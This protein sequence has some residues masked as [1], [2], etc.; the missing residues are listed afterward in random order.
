MLQ[1]FFTESLGRKPKR[2]KPR[3]DAALHNL[4]GSYDLLL[5]VKEFISSWLPVCL[6]GVGITSASITQELTPGV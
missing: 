6:H 3:E 5:E 2:I 4:C 1:Q